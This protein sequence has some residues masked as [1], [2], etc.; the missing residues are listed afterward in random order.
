[1]VDEWWIIISNR[2]KLDKLEEGV[3]RLYEISLQSVGPKGNTN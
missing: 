3:G 1:M 2:T